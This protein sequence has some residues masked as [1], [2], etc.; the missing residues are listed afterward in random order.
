MNTGIKVQCDNLSLNVLTGK[1]K[2]QATKNILQNVT[3]T[4]KP[5]RMTAIMGSSGAGKTSLLSLLVCSK[6]QSIYL[7]IF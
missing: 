7:F 1:G 4:F 6:D 2:K 5:G 3:A